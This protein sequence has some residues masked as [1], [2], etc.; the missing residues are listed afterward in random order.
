MGCEYTKEDLEARMLMLK[1]KRLA[2]RQQRRKK[3]EKLE[4]LTGEKIIIEPIPDYLD[5]T[6]E[7]N[8]ANKENRK[9]EQKENIFNKKNDF[10]FGDDDD[11]N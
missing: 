4:K 9:I 1:I 11:N 10:D 5:E 6:N 3:I 2:I 7:N 8:P